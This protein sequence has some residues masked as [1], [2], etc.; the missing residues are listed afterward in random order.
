MQTLNHSRSQV[1]LHL[2]FYQRYM[3]ELIKDI[4]HDHTNI[5]F[6][7][8]NILNKEQVYLILTC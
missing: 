5:N 8:L 6:L 7:I 3:H 4:Y 1:F 2:A